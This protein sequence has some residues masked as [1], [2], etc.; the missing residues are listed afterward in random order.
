MAI[1]TAWAEG[2]FIDAS[3][4]SGS[5]VTVASS[6]DKDR[7]TV[8]GL[9]DKYLDNQ[10]YSNGSINSRTKAWLNFKLSLPEDPKISLQGRW[11]QFLD[12]EG[13]T[14]G[15]LSSRMKGYFETELSQ[16]YHKCSL[17]AV[18]STWLKSLT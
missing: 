16:T 14:T 12:S 3:F 8:Q 10:G 4:I 15:G 2:S 5:W 11:L 7:L 17:K 18:E 6:F 1:G 13:Q 9:W